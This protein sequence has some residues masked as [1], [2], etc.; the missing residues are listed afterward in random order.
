MLSVVPHIAQE[1]FKLPS[2]MCACQGVTFKPKKWQSDPETQCM[3]GGFNEFLARCEVLDFEADPKH[4]HHK[5]AGRDGRHS[6]V[7]LNF[8]LS[9][10][11]S[12][13][14][15]PPAS[16]P[17]SGL[18]P[19]IEI[20][21]CC[22]YGGKCNSEFIVFAFHTNSCVPLQYSQIDKFAMRPI[23]DLDVSSWE[24]RIL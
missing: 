17:C 14:L 11:M 1:K 5:L 3:Q 10:F 22:M 15:P 9:I 19:Q 23:S 24:V 21:G 2:G 16:C 13:W 8:K 4:H 12:C 7:Q 6:K 18:L 20:Q